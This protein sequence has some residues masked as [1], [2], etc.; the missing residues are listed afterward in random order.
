MNEKTHPYHGRSLTTS[1]LAALAG[2][3]RSTMKRR[4]CR[5]SAEE[6]VALGGPS[7]TGFN[8]KSVLYEFNGEKLT[9]SELSRRTGISIQTLH[10]RL[11]TMGQSV[12]V[13]VAMKALAKPASSAKLSAKSWSIE[14]RKADKRTLKPTEIPGEAIVT[15]KTVVTVAP[16]PRDRFYVD[17]AYVLPT[18]GRIGQYE[19]TGSAIARQ[20]GA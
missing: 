4:L 17:P 7:P 19:D 15:P 18:F 12:Q 13:A 11:K 2:C 3:I 1:E 16:K 8:S 6:A 9:C 14:E 5:M 10:Y 20:Y